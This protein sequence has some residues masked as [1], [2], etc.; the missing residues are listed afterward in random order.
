MRRHKYPLV[1]LFTAA[2]TAPGL[3]A[4]ATHAELS[5]PLQT[6]LAGG[7]ILAAS[8]LLLWACEAAQTDIPQTLALA[9]VAL[10][11][12]L[13]EYAVD[14][15]FTWQAGRNPGAG[16]EHYAIAN[17]TGANR[18]IIG[19]AW[20][21]VV[22]IFWL[23]TRRAVTLDAERHL[24]IRFL[25]AATI[26][27]FLIPLKG[28][29]AW[30]DGVVFIGLYIWY[31]VL[32]SR[33][34]QTEFEAEGPAAWICSLARANRRATFTSMFV[35]SALVIVANAERFSEGLLGTGKAYGINEFLLV[36]WLAPVASEAPEFV[37]A[38]MFALRGHATLALGSL[39]SSKLNQ[40][41]LLVGMI[42]GVYAW[43]SGHI[44]PMPMDALQN[45]EVML[46]AAQSLLAVVMI[47]SMRLSGAQALLLFVLF[48]GQ[49][50]SPMLVDT[51]FGG[52]LMG[53]KADQMHPLFSLL[54]LA[55]A[56]ALLADQPGRFKRLWLFYKEPSATA[57]KPP[58]GGVEG[59]TLVTEDAVVSPET[60]GNQ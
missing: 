26:Y 31:V 23:K 27:A 46:T 47:A 24:E 25:A 10:I 40:W 53:L 29:I 8:F 5:A 60:V 56:L 20:T 32:A 12:V 49:L 38:I 52:E 7:A 16:Y 33:R 21:L 45:H 59:E 19:L 3:Y 1:I 18:L 22:G 36:Q 41:S 50:I 17:M 30:Y 51:W 11:A 15:Y 43:A 2:L 14:M 54:Y 9:V 55:A 28:S 35:F 48:I 42:P 39:L 57:A 37:V 6:L 58:R 34:P 13:P 4:A 44:I